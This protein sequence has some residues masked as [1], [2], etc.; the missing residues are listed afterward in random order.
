MTS[1]EIMYWTSFF[2][3]RPKDSER[4]D[5]LISLM[6]LSITDFRNANRSKGG[7]IN[8]V[9]DLLPNYMKQKESPNKSIKQQ[10]KDALAWAAMYKSKTGK[11]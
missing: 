7:R 6:A 2:E 1:S 9:N 3:G 5:Y 4:L 10:E 11:R 8:Q